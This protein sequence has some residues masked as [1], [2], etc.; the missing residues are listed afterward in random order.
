MISKKAEAIFSFRSS[1][2]LTNGV[3]FRQK[4]GP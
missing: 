2:D 1:I 3:Q 4:V